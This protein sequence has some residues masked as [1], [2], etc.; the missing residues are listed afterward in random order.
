[1]APEELCISDESR[2]LLPFISEIYK[3]SYGEE[4]NYSKLNF[5]L[6][7]ELMVMN[8]SPTKQYDWNENLYHQMK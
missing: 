6:V 2:K 1:M 4:P 8:I 3:L 7:K 5:I